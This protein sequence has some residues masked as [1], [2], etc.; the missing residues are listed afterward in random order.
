MRQQHIK[1]WIQTLIARYQRFVRR[2]QIFIRILQ[3]PY[4]VDASVAEFFVGPVQ[5]LPLKLLGA[6][7]L[8]DSYRMRINS[9]AAGITWLHILQLRKEVDFI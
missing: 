9:L 3:S 4:S 2:Q 1:I 7:F 8:N 5:D 6:R